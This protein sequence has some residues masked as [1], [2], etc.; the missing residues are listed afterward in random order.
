M[1]F[2]SQILYHTVRPALQILLLATLDPALPLPV[3]FFSQY[4][5][6]GTQRYLLKHSF[7]PCREPCNDKLRE[8][9][10]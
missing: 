7:K 8:M 2:F 9:R 6:V 10:T 5:I 1:F 3:L 4:A